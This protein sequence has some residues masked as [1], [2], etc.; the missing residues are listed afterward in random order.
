[1]DIPGRQLEDLTKLFIKDS[2]QNKIE[3]VINCKDKKKFIKGGKCFVGKKKYEETRK[4]F[5]AEL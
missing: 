2:R 3:T 5:N 4:A 1:M